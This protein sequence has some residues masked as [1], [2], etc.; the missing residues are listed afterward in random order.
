MSKIL[1]LKEF[2]KTRRKVGR[3]FMI[4]NYGFEFKDNIYPNF[5]YVYGID[6]SYG[7]IEINNNNGN[8]SLKYF[9]NISNWDDVSN[10]LEYFE[11]KLYTDHYLCEL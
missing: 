11:E 10:D 5:Y 9:L 7:Y 4:E 8:N 3:K 1:T 2:Q 6:G